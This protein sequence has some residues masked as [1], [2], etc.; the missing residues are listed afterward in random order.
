MLGK[1]PNFPSVASP[2]TNKKLRRDGNCEQP[3]T[4]VDVCS[5]K[6]APPDFVSYDLSRRSDAVNMDQG[7]Q[8]RIVHL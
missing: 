3:A 4:K 8:A 6:D 2:S 1:P 5:S 7:T